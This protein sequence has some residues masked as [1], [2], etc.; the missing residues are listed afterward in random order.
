MTFND[1]SNLQR[2]AAHLLLTRYVSPVRIIIFI[3]L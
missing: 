2:T 3:S 1:G